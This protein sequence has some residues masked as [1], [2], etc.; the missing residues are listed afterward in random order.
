[1]VTT[2]MKFK[3]ICFLEEKLWQTWWFGGL[4]A[5]SCPTLE[6]PWT[7]ACQVPLF[8]G[9]YRQGYWSGLRF[10]LQGIFPTQESNPGLLHCRQILYHLEAPEKPMNTGVGSLL[11]LQGS[12]RPRNRTGVSCIAGKFFTSWAISY[13]C[14]FID[15]WVLYSLGPLRIKLL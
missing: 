13:A 1:M 6:A 5:E 7:V 10:L 11:L 12:S 2:A 15:L 9:C 4:V 14:L 8:M 3:D